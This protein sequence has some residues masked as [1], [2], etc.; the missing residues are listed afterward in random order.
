M[1]EYVMDIF[2]KICEIENTDFKIHDDYT[3]ITYIDRETVVTFNSPDTRS[4]RGAVVN[5]RSLGNIFVQG[6][7]K[8]VELKIPLMRERRYNGK[9]QSRAYS[10]DIN[11]TVSKMYKTIELELD[12]ITNAILFNPWYCNTYHTIF[13]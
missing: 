8:M 4:P 9:L 7:E 6:R 5:K 13:N 2:G 12:H 10:L 1:D 3:K 11:T